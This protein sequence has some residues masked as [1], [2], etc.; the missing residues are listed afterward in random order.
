MN[1]FNKV[2]K[3]FVSTMMIV[4]VISANVLQASVAHAE[5]REVIVQD[6]TNKGT[7]KLN[8]A[9]NNQHLLVMDNLIMVLNH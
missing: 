6:N 4:N 1:N 8:Y 9:L 7:I 5:D 3:L 2:T